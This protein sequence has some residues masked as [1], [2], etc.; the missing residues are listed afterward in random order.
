MWLK[1]KLE[2]KLKAE[3]EIE[4]EIEIELIS[5]SLFRVKL[6][7]VTLGFIFGLFLVNYLNFIL[8]LLSIYPF[9]LPLYL[10]VYISIYLCV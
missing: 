1:L 10:N 6:G 5:R 9:Y 3:I 4:I 2:L 7:L 8:N